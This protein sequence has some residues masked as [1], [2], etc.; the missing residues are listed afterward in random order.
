MAVA[1]PSG[2]KVKTTLRRAL[3]DPQLLGHELQGE[4]FEA[5][6]ALLYAAL[7]EP[8]NEDELA[9]FRQLTGRQEPP[10]QRVEKLLVIAGRRAGKS[11]CAA[12][13]AVYQATLVDHVTLRRG[14][15]GLVLCISRTSNNRGS[16][17]TTAKAS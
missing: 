9:A 14:E 1:G 12:L 8:L 13:L 15:R 2:M 10:T 11:L 5:W 3:A 16:C 17:A 7:G 6:R 4:S